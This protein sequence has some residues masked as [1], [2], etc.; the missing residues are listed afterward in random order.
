MD[1][2]DNSRAIF[3]ALW[4]GFVIQVA[5]R[6][7]DL[8]WHLT[9]SG[10][11]SGRQQVQAHWLVWL[12]TLVIL[13]VA[14]WAL[15]ADTPQAERPGY[16]VV[17]VANLLYAVVGVIH[18]VQH[19]NHQEVDWAHVGLAVT[20]LGSLIGVLMVTT[21]WMKSRRDAALSSE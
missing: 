8:Q 2:A 20:N 14:G 18:Y 7:V 11:E 10:F 19:L 13:V 6:L 4:V 12:G 17:L 15:R 5:G 9:H 21:A 16:W 3:K 1:N